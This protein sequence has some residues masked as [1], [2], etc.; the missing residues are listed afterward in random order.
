MEEK[1]PRRAHHLELDNRK[2]LCM[3]G[4]S[5]VISFDLNKVVLETDYGM[6]TI[7]GNDLHVNQLSVEKGALDIDG[8]IHALEYAETTSYAKKGESFFGKLLK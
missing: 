8:K 7:K 4:I 5:D 2:K 3:T 1:Q 6:L